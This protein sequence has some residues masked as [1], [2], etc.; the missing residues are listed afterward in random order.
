MPICVTRTDNFQIIGRA[1]DDHVVWGLTKLLNDCYQLLQAIG[2]DIPTRF[3]S[4]SFI[5]LS[6]YATN[7]LFFFSQLARDLLSIFLFPDLS[8]GQ[9]GQVSRVPVLKDT[10]REDLY[11]LVLSLSKTQDDLDNILDHIDGLVAKGKVIACFCS[12]R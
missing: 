4:V 5:S 11:N 3:V 12:I 2:V 9:P 10:V 7:T 8:D 6:C 1:S